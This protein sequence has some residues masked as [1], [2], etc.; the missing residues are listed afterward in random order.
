[1]PFFFRRTLTAIAVVML[2]ASHAD[3]QSAEVTPFGGYRLGWSV[4]TVAGVPVVDDDGGPSIGVV[5][6][7]PL[8]QHYDGLIFEA[9]FSR[10]RARV[11][12][13]ASFAAPAFATVEVDHLMVGVS[14]ELDASS[15]RARAFISGLVGLTRYAAADDLEV[16]FSLGLAAEGKFFATR[17]LGL[18]VEARGYMTIIGLGGSGV[19]S[20]GCVFVF[21]ANPVFQA[22]LTAGVI[23]A[24]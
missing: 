12:T 23:V 1:V 15:E 13:Q 7:V 10:E 20:G 3:A 4:G 18:R 11:Q 22:D 6:D 21:N 24:F 14:Q 19:C 16:R 5:V 2:V 17:H 8:P 9:L